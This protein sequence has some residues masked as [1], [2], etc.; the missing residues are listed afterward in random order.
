MFKQ[1]SLLVKIASLLLILPIIGAVT[2]KPKIAEANCSPIPVVLIPGIMGTKIIA[3]SAFTTTEN[4]PFSQNADTWGTTPYTGSDLNK[5][6]ANEFIPNGSG[7]VQP[8]YATGVFEAQS[9]ADLNHNPMLD[10][11]KKLTRGVD[12]Y[13]L[14]KAALEQKGYTWN[15]NLFAFGWDWRWG[16]GQKDGQGNYVNVTRLNKFINLVV[17]KTG[18]A[19]VNII[20][21]SQGGYV[22]WLYITTSPDS[23]RVKNLITIGTPHLG[24]PKASAVYLWGVDE[25]SSKYGPTATVTK[26]MAQYM[27]GP[28]ELLPRDPLPRH[29]FDSINS[30]SPNKT[31]SNLAVMDIISN[32]ANNP[33]V[34]TIAKDF[35][36][37][38]TS[39]VKKG[40]KYGTKV[41]TI[42]GSG[43]PSW[44]R[45]MVTNGNVEEITTS[46]DGTVPFKSHKAEGLLPKGFK[47]YFTKNQDHLKSV[48]PG[49]AINI[50][51]NILKGDPWN[52]N[53]PADQAKENNPFETKGVIKIKIRS[54]LN[55]HLYDQS[56][57][58]TGIYEGVD[59]IQIP[60]SVIKNSGDTEHE[61][62][63]APINSTYEVRLES[64]ATSWGS[65]S[66]TLQEANRDMTTK[67][68][69]YENV[70]VSP[71]LKARLTWDGSSTP[72]LELDYDGNGSY[73]TSTSPT[74]ASFGDSDMDGLNDLDETFNYGTNS[75]NSDSDYDGMYDWQE[76]FQIG[77]DPLDFDPDTEDDGWLDR[78]PPT[79]LHQGPSNTNLSYD[80]CPTDYNPG[81]ENKDG[82]FID[83]SP[84][85]SPSADDRTL[86]NSDPF[87]DACDVDDDN[88]GLWDFE[89]ADIA[90]YCPS[91]TGSTTN[92]LAA[93][94][95]GD[96]ILDFAECMMGSN[97]ND[98]NSKPANPPPAQ[99]PDNDK[100]STLLENQIGTNPA[101]PDSDGDK[102]RDNIEFKN[103]NSDPNQLNSDGDICNDPKEVAGLNGDNSVNSGDQLLVTLEFNRVPP[104]P[105]VS[106][107]DLNKDGAINAGDQLMWLQ[108]FIAHP[109]G[110]S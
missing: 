45:I 46:G 24:S 33:E 58:H 110:C 68:V 29:I 7:G 63:T 37:K 64:Y 57:N 49:T 26:R 5:Y 74:S 16:A 104:P 30:L 43:E 22:G 14:L 81:Q 47:V 75:F 106:N 108:I 56:G 54:P 78:P 95:D 83:Q 79:N 89:E 97:P 87:G 102:L 84:P 70:S 73:E 51:N 28:A 60:E 23:A 6:Y 94:S 93:D 8:K 27:P 11:V 61:W 88:D 41:T 80:N 19:Q 91:A 90:T 53:I 39:L 99:D 36:K 69:L 10:E 65:F 17:E 98:I 21:H 55:L 96:L 77:L 2:L 42:A 101:N 31:P 105:D 35:H 107:I 85:Y 86:I 13:N 82:N 4:I 9:I 66:L 50:A 48:H 3:K 71:T 59:E 18:C 67:T 38:Y 103:Y 44:E 40:P 72:P 20:A 109:A 1:R 100:L 62:I 25:S 32:R 76:L 12:A 15:T 92:P 34:I 52:N